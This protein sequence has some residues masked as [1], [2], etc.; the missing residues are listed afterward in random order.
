MGSIVYSA[1]GVSYHAFSLGSFSKLCS[2]LKGMCIE[3]SNDT[4]NE[5][6]WRSIKKIP[7]HDLGAGTH[8]K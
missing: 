4:I 3:G 8:V 7:S 1:F 5:E 2:G 6:R